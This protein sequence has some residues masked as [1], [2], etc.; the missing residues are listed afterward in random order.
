MPPATL[1][2]VSDGPMGEGR[3]YLG[4]LAEQ[5]PPP[6]VRALI[7]GG[8]LAWRDDPAV[9]GGSDECGQQQCRLT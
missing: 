8:G 6:A 2:G 1:Q 4:S 3:R 5:L 7:G 9:P